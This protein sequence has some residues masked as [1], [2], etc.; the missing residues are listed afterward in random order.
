MWVVLSVCSTLIY[1]LVVLLDRYVMA[2]GLANPSTYL[3]IGSFAGLAV[4][5]AI[6]GLDL[7]TIDWNLAHVAA[8]IVS[9]ICFG[10]FTLLYLETLRTSSPVTTVAYM[11]ILPVVTSISAIYILRQDI[12]QSGFVA[13]LLV[14]AGLTCISIIDWRAPSAAARKMIPALA[15]LSAAYLLQRILLESMSPV[16]LLALNRLGNLLVGAG[17]LVSV[18]RYTTD[19]SVPQRTRAGRRIGWGAALV[20]ELGSIGGLY[21]LLLAYDSGPFAEISAVAAT[22]PVFVL[23]GAVMLGR[24]GGETFK[25]LPEL[26][27]IGT[28][29]LSVLGV[30]AIISAI[31]L[32]ST[33]GGPG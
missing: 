33:T 5:V 26:R 7:K 30:T 13:I 31:W 17:A 27:S 19:P 23:G 4:S 12:P 25:E 32:L 9:G 3:G 28:V 8:A 15:V 21:L 10:V 22:L 24:V 2:R 29:L 20:G 11:Q 6:L 1:A 14:I 16:D 18:R